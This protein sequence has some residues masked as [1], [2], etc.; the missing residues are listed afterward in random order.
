MRQRTTLSLMTARFENGRYN[1]FQNGIDSSG[2]GNANCLLADVKLKFE[3]RSEEWD[4]K[5]EQYEKS[6]QEHTLF[7]PGAKGKD[8]A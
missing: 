8:H 5:T 7:Q 3:V 6:R 2:P 4:W 1:T